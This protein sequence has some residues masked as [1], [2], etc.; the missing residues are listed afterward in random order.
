MDLQPQSGLVTTAKVRV[1]ER[2]TAHGWRNVAAECA[3]GPEKTRQSTAGAVKAVGKGGTSTV[4]GSGGRI[5][6][7]VGLVPTTLQHAVAVVGPA[8]LSCTRTPTHP[9]PTTRYSVCTPAH[10]DE[11]ARRSDRLAARAAAGRG[12]QQQQHNQYPEPHRV[13]DTPAAQAPPTA[14][15]HHLPAR[16]LPSSLPPCLPPGAPLGDPLEVERQ[17]HAAI[18]YAACKVG[19]PGTGPGSERQTATV[20]LGAEAVPGGEC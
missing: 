1:S 9:H 20:G 6:N 2:G 16:G 3:P 11:A 13:R 7:G 14:R 10:G 19:G 17:L 4:S 8:A 5:R 12:P 15:P 18:S